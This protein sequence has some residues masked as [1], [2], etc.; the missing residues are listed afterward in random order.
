MRM[1]IKPRAAGVAPLEFFCP[2]GGGYIRLETPGRPGTLGRQ[3]CR[4]GGLTGSTLS[5]CGEADFKSECRKWYR[6]ARRA[7]LGR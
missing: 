5:A 6:A 7:S 4:G 3:I 2:D 1:I